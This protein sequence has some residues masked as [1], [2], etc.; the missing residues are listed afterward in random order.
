MANHAST[1]KAIRKTISKTIINKSRKTRIRTCIKKVKTAVDSG[2]VQEANKA[3][4]DAQSEI[5]RGV[6][7]NI[8]KKNTAS[9]KISRLASRVKSIS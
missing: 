2:F 5:M 4:I 8:I 9:R 3:L 6:S 1:K 7:C